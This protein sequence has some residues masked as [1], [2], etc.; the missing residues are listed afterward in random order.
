MVCRQARPH[1]TVCRRRFLLGTIF[2]AS[3]LTSASATRVDAHGFAVFCGGFG[4][5]YV[6]VLYRAGK[7]AQAATLATSLVDYGVSRKGVRVLAG[8]RDAGRIAMILER[9]GRPEAA[10]LLATQVRA[11][12]RWARGE[13][14]AVASSARP[15]RVMGWT[16]VELPASAPLVVSSAAPVSVPSDPGV[17]MVYAVAVRDVL[18]S[19][20]GKPVTEAARP[21]EAAIAPPVVVAKPAR[22]RIAVKKP[23][24]LPASASTGV[25]K[26][27]SGQIEGWV[28]NAFGR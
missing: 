16:S 12:R 17:P 13:V 20:D 22:P 4:D 26:A 24:S 1:Q 9:I 23:K 21:P 3:V 2:A 19:V 11:L 6:S 10:P 15:P 18:D 14:E 7:Y 27:P 25:A 28:E 8:V 5:Y